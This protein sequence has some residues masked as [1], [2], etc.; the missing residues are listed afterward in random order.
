MLLCQS[1]H[2]FLFQPTE[3]RIHIKEGAPPREIQF[4]VT[5]P[6]GC[7]GVNRQHQCSVGV[8]L[9]TPE[10]QSAGKQC[11]NYA[12]RNSISFDRH[13]CGIEIN[14][15]SWNSR[16]SLNI[17]GNVDNMVN[18][19]E[20][21][22]FIRLGVNNSKTEDAS[23]VWDNVTIPDIQVFLSFTLLFPT[24]NHQKSNYTCTF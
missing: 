14:S 23:R 2:M 10:Y 1:L 12:N 6:V 5:V 4:R 21:E 11:S 8:Y 18:K 7:I 17:T 9:R 19:D 15:L 16:K 13:G 24:L 20:R 22:I 3:K